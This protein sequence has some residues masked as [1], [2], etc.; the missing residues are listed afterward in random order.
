MTPATWS[1]GPA[2]PHRRQEKLSALAGSLKGVSAHYLRMW[3]PP[4]GGRGECPDHIK[5]HLWGERFWSPSYFVASCGGAPL[6]AVKEHI[7]NQK[8]PS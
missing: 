8:R 7:E 2:R 3:A 6:S 4:A 5:R 1:A